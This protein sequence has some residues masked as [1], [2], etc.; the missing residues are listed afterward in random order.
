[1]SEVALEVSP[2]VE[3]HQRELPV[4]R[5]EQFRRLEGRRVTVVVFEGQGP[6]DELPLRVEAPGHR[7]RA[8]ELR[9]EFRRHRFPRLMVVREPA[10]RRRISDPFLEHL[11]G[12]LDEVPLD[13]VVRVLDPAAVTSEHRVEQVPELVEQ[14]LDLQVLHEGRPLLRIGEVAHQ[15]GLR[16]RRL[17]GPSDQDRGRRVCVLVLPR[18][19][20]QVEPA[21]PLRALV[22]IVG[23]DRLVPHGDVG[24]ALVPNAEKFRGDVEEAP[25]DLLEGEVRPQELRVE[26]ERLGADQFRVVVRVPCVER[27]RSRRVLAFSV[28]EKAGVL[29]RPTFRRRA[30]LREEVRD[31]FRGADHLVLHNVVREGVVSEQRGELVPGLEELR[32]CREIRG[33]RAVE[34]LSLQPSAHL[35]VLR[36]AEDGDE[37]RIVGRDRDLAVGTGRMGPHEVVREAREVLRAVD[38]DRPDVFSDRAIEVLP[39]RGHLVAQFLDPRPGGLVL[40]DARETEVSEDFSHRELRVRVLARHVEADERIVEGPVQREVRREALRLLVPFVRRRPDRG[41][42]MDVEQELRLAL[43]LGEVEQQAIVGDEEVADRPPAMALEDLGQVAA[44]LL[45][46]R[47]GLPLQGIRI[48]DEQVPRLRE[49]GHLG[50]RSPLRGRP[51]RGHAPKESSAG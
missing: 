24:D 6:Q 29:L 13:P 41:V 14:G 51:P 34:V 48:A 4:G 22:H 2:G 21:D 50:R 10:E 12:G 40:V 9:E 23:L 17:A 1:M 27:R 28:E 20:I 47:G 39:D 31:P 3:R 37:V 38:L 33:M 42:R 11:G 25:Q 19:E 30:D 32:E 46:A 18:M 7:I 45:Q 15:G 49:R 36:I 8:S 43:D 35:R 26:I 5:L 44:A 16:E